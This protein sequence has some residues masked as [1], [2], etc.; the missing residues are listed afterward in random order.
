MQTPAKDPVSSPDGSERGDVSKR[1]DT[2]RTSST[3]KNWSDH[4]IIVSITLAGTLLTILVTVW[5]VLK[6][7]AEYKAGSSTASPDQ[8][9]AQQPES[10]SA[11]ASEVITRTPEQLIA[12]YASQADEIEARRQAKILYVGKLV[13]ISGNPDIFAVHSGGVQFKIGKT[14]AAMRLDTV[15][16]RN[17]LQSA[18]RGSFLCLVEK[19]EANSLTVQ[20]CKFD[21]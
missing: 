14:Y 11:L 8:K 20:D 19:I 1:V 10:K 4:P 2:G 3:W 17:Q 13:R 18:L 15:K 5:G 12:W 21:E 7:M 16:Q 6:L 9:L